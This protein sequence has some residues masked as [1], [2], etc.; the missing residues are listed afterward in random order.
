[1]LSVRAG[2][3]DVILLH[4][5]AIVWPRARALLVA[6]LHFG[7][8]ATFRGHGIPVPEATTGD[9]LARLDNAIARARE[10]APIN[11]LFILGDLIHAHDGRQPEVI[12]AITAWAARPRALEITLIRGNHDRRAGDPPCDWGM[13]CIDGPLIEHSLALCHEP[14]VVK[15]AYTLAGHIHPVITM[16]GPTGGMRAPCFW[17]GPAIAVLPAFGAFTGGQSISPTRADRIYA[18]GPREVVEVPLGRS[19]NR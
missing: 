14:Q 18:V 9:T 7:K 13:T 16:S 10:L 17:F 19:A 3:E 6:D 5:R 1:M 11:R 2:E 12:D 8:A 15:N 4:Q